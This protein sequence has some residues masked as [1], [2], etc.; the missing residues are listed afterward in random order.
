VKLRLDPKVPADLERI[1]ALQ[2]RLVEFAEQMRT[3][4][5]LLDVP[6]GL[7]ERRI[8]N[9]RKQFSSSYARLSS[10]AGRITA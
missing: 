3:F 7:T 6:P 5:A 8:L 10:M 2:R 4:V 1:T 9:W